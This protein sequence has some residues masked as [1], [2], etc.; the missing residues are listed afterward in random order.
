[1]LWLNAVGPTRIGLHSEMERMQL[2]IKRSST[3]IQ[4]QKIQDWIF[5]QKFKD[6]DQGSG[7]KDQGSKIRS[8][9]KE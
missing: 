8:R 3:R 7:S 6:Q 1:M 4:F 9:I 5:K 2:M